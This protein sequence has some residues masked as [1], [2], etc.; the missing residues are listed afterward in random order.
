M[1]ERLLR[2]SAAHD[3]IRGLATVTT[4]I[5]EIRAIIDHEGQAEVWCEF[6]AERYV[7]GRDELA[8]LLV[9]AA[10]TA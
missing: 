7:V 4:G 3:T 10:G 6:C 5:A 8:M 2:V 1:S 9:D